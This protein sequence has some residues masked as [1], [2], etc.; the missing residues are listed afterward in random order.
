MLR[1]VRSFWRAAAG[2]AAFERDMDDELRFHLESRTAEL[3]GRGLPAGEA[4]RRARLEFGNA[5]VYRDR[6]RDS[7]RLTLLDDLQADLRF[8][9]RAMRKDAPLTL[10]IV[11]TLAL[12][13]GATGAMF[14]A[15][16]AAL[17]RPLPFSDPAQLVIVS[18]GGDIQAVP[19]PDF[20]EWQAG[21]GA[22]AGLAAFTQWESTIAGGAEPERVL[23]G[24]VTPGFF[25]V[26]GLQPVLGR[27]FLPEELPHSE[28][29]IVDSSRRSTAVILGA[30]LWRRQFHGDA[31][32]VGRTIRVDNAPTLVVGVMPDGFAFPDRADAWVPADV[33]TTRR[34]ATLRVI[35]RLKPGVSL[36]QG[37]TAF[38]TLIARAESA[39]PDE[40][41]IHDVA[42]VPLQEYLVGDVRTS[43]MIFL[44]AVAL[45][46]LIACANVANLLLAQAAT[47]PR[48]MAIRTILGAGRRRL[49]R[50]LLT[51]SLLLAIAGG[52]GGLALTAWILAVFR[53]TLPEAVPRL[54]AIAVD[55]SVVVF[56][57][58]ISIGAGLLFGLAP[59]WRSASPD[60]NAALKDGATRGAGGP[61]RRRVRGTLVIAEVSLAMILLIGAGLL[62]KSLV[63]LQTRPLGFAPAGVMTANVTLPEADYTTAPQVKTFL[64]QALSHIQQRREIQ[65]AGC[66]NALPLSRHGTRVRGDAKIDGE[67]KERK[68]A[69]PAKIAVGG[70]YFAAMG[71]PLLRGRLLEARDAA[72]AA[73]VV[74]VSQSFADRVWPNQDP[75]GHRIST[76]FG[77]NPWAEVVGV[78]ADVK[79][80]GLRQNV[81]QAVYH[82]Y[83]QVADSRRWFLGEMTFVVRGASAPAA[84]A[85]LRGTFQE[86]DRNLPL[87]AVAPMT[88]VVANNTSDPRF[89]ALLMGSFSLVAFVLAMAGVYGVVSYSARQRT[90]ELG[91]RVALGARRFDI[92]A[93][94]LREGM[95]LVGI[96]ALLGIAGSYAATRTLARFLFRVTV[97]DPATFVTVPILL[98]AVALIACYIPARRATAV[99]P[100]RALRYE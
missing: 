66:V 18:S 35:A 19:G 15:V 88:D 85:A 46:L 32:I 68:G 64:A 54:N 52:L 2:R 69:F 40:R 78:V 55:W 24:R 71:I 3:V 10:T 43:L 7:R 30:S 4:A 47:R 37:A 14:T 8:S 17:L 42:L 79:H 87:Y 26:L 33:P 50:Q 9:L 34:N 94:V 49:L 90:H 20:V 97:T 82:P 57:A 48:E 53:G 86:L 81:S 22:C 23:V 91:V 41:R 76:G 39:R 92:A 59:A 13:I 12:G 83:A 65:S 11:A 95:L 73:P 1:R 36:V 44:A 96:G 75:I 60:L 31:A 100:L 80:D 77:S 70:D 28:S 93:L 56:V 74:V 89:Y 16:N 29:G 25:G 67:D 63:L 45:V 21:C 72:G 6:C 61:N 62:I 84:V 27:T 58:S 38:R 5:A 51:E 98:C 99:D